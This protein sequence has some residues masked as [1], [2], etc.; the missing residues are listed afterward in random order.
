M[1]PL[2]KMSYII[3]NQ[4]EIWEV[5]LLVQL[6]TDKQ[7]GGEQIGYNLLELT[8]THVNRTCNKICQLCRQYNESN[9]L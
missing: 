7:S 2:L 8:T 5:G 9:Y 6:P 4:A 3:Y 1:T